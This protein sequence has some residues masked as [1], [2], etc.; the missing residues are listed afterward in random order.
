[1]SLH[2]RLILTLCAAALLTPPLAAQ[3][4][5]PAPPATYDVHLRYSIRAGTNQRIAQ[6][7]EMT[8]YFES[9]GFVRV[10]SDDPQEAADP[11]AERMR[12]TLPSDKVRDLLLDSHVRT[13][14]LTPAG[15]ALPENPDQR[16]LVQLQLES[17]LSARLQRD[18]AN[19][20]RARL[21]GIGFVEKVGYDHQANVRLLGTI[22]AGEVATLVGDLRD[23]PAG[24]LAPDV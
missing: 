16:V 6:F 2:R 7:Q 18:L 24:W 20:A 12:G 17:H 3:R 22:P 14:R 21:A 11:T 4:T 1:M 5:A 10:P 19:Q 13:I 8:R 9:I 23:V 15:M